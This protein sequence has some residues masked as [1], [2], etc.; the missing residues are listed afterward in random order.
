MTMTQKVNNMIYNMTTQNCGLAA[1]VMRHAKIAAHNAF[2]R[3]FLALLMMLLNL[4]MAF[5]V[6]TARPIH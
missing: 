2:G 3:L 4:V 1:S 5:A 6:Q